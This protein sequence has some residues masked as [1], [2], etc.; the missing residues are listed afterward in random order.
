MERIN[1]F[2]DEDLEQYLTLELIH[3][4]DNPPKKK[5]LKNDVGVRFIPKGGTSFICGNDFKICFLYFLTYQLIYKHHSNRHTSNII[6][7]HNLAI[8]KQ[9]VAQVNLLKNI[10]IKNKFGQLIDASFP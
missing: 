8:I 2:E 7:Q 3:E 4:L 10:Y 1:E 9:N 6:Y 5:L